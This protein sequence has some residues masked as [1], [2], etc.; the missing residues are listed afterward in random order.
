MPGRVGNDPGYFSSNLDY[1]LNPISHY[2]KLYPHQNVVKLNIVRILYKVT[3]F[4]F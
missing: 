3:Q 2:A 4:A 1:N